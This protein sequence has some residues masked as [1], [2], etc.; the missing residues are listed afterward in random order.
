MSELE[1]LKEKTRTLILR[2]N[3]NHDSK[4]RFS[5]SN[6]SGGGSDGGSSSSGGSGS[7]NGKAKSQVDE[8]TNLV[9]SRLSNDIKPFKKE[10]SVDMKKVEERAG[11][12]GADAKKCVDVAESVYSTAAAKEPA[13]TK[14]VVSAVDGV[15]GKMYGLNSR[16]KQPTSMAGKIGA[17]AHDD[18]ITFDQAGSKIKDAV[19]YTAVVDDSNFTSGYNS[20]K[21]NLENK[22]YKEVRCKN[23]Y[24]S[25]AD[26]KSDQKAVQCIYEDPSGYKFE[27]QFHTPRSQGAKELNHPLYEEQRN[28]TTSDKRRKELSAQMKSYAEE[29]PNPKGVLTIKSH[30]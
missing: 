27:L 30:G 6:G 2:Y 15:D 24:Q 28:A 12:G 1:L 18:G 11:V 10:S 9:K 20:I 17:D 4:G 16:L 5:S 23:F 19:R 22:G 21:S 3:P 26:G 25:Y 29:V 14:D 8:K 7:S 13:I